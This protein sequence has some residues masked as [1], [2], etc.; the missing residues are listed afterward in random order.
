L[1]HELHEDS[2]PE[3]AGEDDLEHLAPNAS[4]NARGG[5][6]DMLND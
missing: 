2:T 4:G 3:L 5:S 1:Q 6:E